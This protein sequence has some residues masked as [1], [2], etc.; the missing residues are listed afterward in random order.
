MPE[1]VSTAVAGYTLALC[2]ARGGSAVSRE[3]QAVREAASAFVA[4][5]ERSIALFGAK[6][7]LISRIYEVAAECGHDSWGGEDEVSMPGLVVERAIDFVRA[8]PDGLALPD[9]APEPDGSISFDWIEDRSKVFR[10]ALERRIGSRLPGST[11]QIA[12]TV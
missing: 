6:G 1:P 3:A 4:S 8:F 9:V 5:T 11:A 10:S 2:L 12:A 7:S